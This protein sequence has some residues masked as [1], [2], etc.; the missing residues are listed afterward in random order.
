MSERVVR[1]S[2]ERLAGRLRVVEAR[3]D[4]TSAARLRS[5]AT[6]EIR[7]VRVWVARNDNTPPDAL[8]LLARD[9]DEIVRWYALLH[10][11][12][13]S[14][15]LEWLADE[16]NR[17]YGGRWFLVRDRVVHHPN[18]P[19]PLRRSLLRAG[20]CRT[21]SPTCPGWRVMDRSAAG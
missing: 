14:S 6:D 10:P 13:P 20:A 7:P 4:T 17:R 12:T 19:E 3:A 21:C 15:A 9:P 8:D 18:A 2:A 11:R 1:P 5:L 16:E